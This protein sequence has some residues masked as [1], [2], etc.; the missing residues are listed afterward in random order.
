MYTE[1]NISHMFIFSCGLPFQQKS[2]KYETH[3]HINLDF[4]CIYYVINTYVHLEKRHLW[5]QPCN[6]GVAE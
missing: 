5:S 4:V 2:Y 6:T 3:M 1:D